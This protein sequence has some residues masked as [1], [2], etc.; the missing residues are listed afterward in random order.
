MKL[1]FILGNQLFPSKY[2]DRFKKDHLFF[3]AEDYELCTYEKHHKLKILLFLSS[4]RSHAEELKK[5]KLKLEIDK[6]KELINLGK[7][8]DAIIVLDN[9]KVSIEEYAD[10]YSKNQNI[11]KESIKRNERIN[12]IDR[13]IKSWINLLSNSGLTG[14]SLVLHFLS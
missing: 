9:C 8:E 1:F 11:K 10:S 14:S 4:M 7:N 5:N 3:M 13:E 6:V 2:I 12:I